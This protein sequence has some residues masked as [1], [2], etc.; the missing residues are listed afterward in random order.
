MN[1]NVK[2][3]GAE[4][5]GVKYILHSHQESNFHKISRLFAC[6]LFIAVGSFDCIVTLRQ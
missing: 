1:I 3:R 4:G 2:T 5:V 6:L